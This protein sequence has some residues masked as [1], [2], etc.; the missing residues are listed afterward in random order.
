MSVGGRPSHT[1]FGDIKMIDFSKD[2]VLTKF[3]L[4]VDLG[5][6]ELILSKLLYKECK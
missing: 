3:E 6:S 1:I 2:D 4:R 5:T